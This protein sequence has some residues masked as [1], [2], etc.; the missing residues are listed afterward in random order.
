[1]EER[2]PYIRF[3]IDAAQVIAGA[4]GLIVFLSGTVCS[5]HQGGFA[6]FMSFL[7]TIVISCVAYVAIMVWIES[8]RIFVDIE[9]TVRQLLTAQRPPAPPPGTAA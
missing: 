4:I 3:I 2:Y 6:G 5:C 7:I 1:M 9:D 8:L